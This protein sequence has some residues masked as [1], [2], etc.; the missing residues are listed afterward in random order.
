MWL[1][2]ET[3]YDELVGNHKHR[4]RLMGP[5]IHSYLRVASSTSTL[6]SLSIPLRLCSLAKLSSTS[7]PSLSSARRRHGRA[8]E[9]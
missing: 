8:H 9:L 2:L 5:G 6:A 1:Y 4:N 7:L 3:T